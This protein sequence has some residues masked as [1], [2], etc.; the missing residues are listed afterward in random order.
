MTAKP[1]EPS[2]YETFGEA[3]EQ[4]LRR[5]R[6]ARP[7]ALV[8]VA[9]LSTAVVVG[10]GPDPS[11]S[12][13]PQGTTGIGAGGAAGASGGAGG[14]TTGGE[15]GTTAGGSG[16]S[17]GSGGTGGGGSGMSGTGA[18]CGSDEPGMSGGVSDPAMVQFIGA[19]L[20]AGKITLKAR[21]KPVPAADPASKDVRFTFR[22]LAPSNFGV[23]ENYLSAEV[24]F[25]AQLAGALP[26]GYEEWHGT[27][28]LPFISDRHPL[29]LLR[30][31]YNDGAGALYFDDNHGELHAVHCLPGGFDSPGAHADCTISRDPT[32]T[33]VTITDAGIS[34]HIE[35]RA[36]HL[37]AD[38]T[39]VVKWTTDNWTTVHEVPMAWAGTDGCY[40]G[41]WVADL[42][43][44]G[45]FVALKYVLEYKHGVVGGATPTVFWDDNGGV[46]YV[47]VK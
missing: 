38:N 4:A 29:L 32:K 18:A 42:D 28:E 26:D 19:Q 35:A 11:E 46:G 22:K 37:D 36:P 17:A 45:N 39:A 12:T 40:V 14:E 33:Q 16:G 7:S 43:V 20:E 47:V 13:A 1:T 34:G 9:A 44:P 27:I 21:V 6:A 25:V 3:F 41:R 23:P 5:L 24:S 8:G 15:A 10:C 31:W 2:A 30:A